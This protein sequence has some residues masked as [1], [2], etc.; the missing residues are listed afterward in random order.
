MAG[1]LQDAIPLT[2]GAQTSKRCA[3]VLGSDAG[4]VG[5]EVQVHPDQ[6]LTVLGAERS[7]MTRKLQDAI[8]TPGCRAAHGLPDPTHG[9]AREASP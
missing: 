5:P 6:W 7:G 1:E 8:V 2:L 3:E 9:V 4:T